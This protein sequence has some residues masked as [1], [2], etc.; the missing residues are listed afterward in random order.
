MATGVYLPVLL[1]TLDV[2]TLLCHS[3]VPSQEECS[4]WDIL[5]FKSV[6]RKL[7][8]IHTFSSSILQVIWIKGGVPLVFPLLRLSFQDLVTVE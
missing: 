5:A 2:Q 7:E 1:Q 3:K 8:I 4:I 6:I